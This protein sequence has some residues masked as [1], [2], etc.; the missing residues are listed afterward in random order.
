[1]SKQFAIFEPCGIVYMPPQINAKACGACHLAYSSRFPA[2][3]LTS[4][5]HTFFVVIFVPPF[6]GWCLLHFMC[7]T[8]INWCFHYMDGCDL[9]NTNIVWIWYPLVFNSIW[10]SKVLIWKRSRSQSNLL[11]IYTYINVRRSFAV[12][13]INVC[14]RI[15][16]SKCEPI[17]SHMANCVTVRLQ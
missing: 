17:Y 16:V 13:Y 12:H 6:G 4:N 5:V 14:L 3:C 10:S 11:Y 15:K 8:L 7:L 2:P 1:M 9:E